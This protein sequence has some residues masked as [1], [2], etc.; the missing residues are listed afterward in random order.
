[1]EKA[2]EAHT[3]AVLCLRWNYEGSALVSGKI[4][5]HDFNNILFKLGGEDGVIKIWSRTGMLRSTLIKSNCPIYS[6]A[7][8]SNN[9]QCLYTNGKNLVIKSLQPGN[10]PFQWK[11]HDGLI[12]KVDWSLV[13]G[14]IVSCGEDKRYKVI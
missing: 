12:L 5:F 1:V 9:E 8:S 10:K 11:A 13:N 7:W 2:I 6:V 14:L 4:F 3:G